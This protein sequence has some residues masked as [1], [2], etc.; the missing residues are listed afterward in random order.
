MK[1]LDLT[2]GA[3]LHHPEEKA[4][5]IELIVSGSLDIISSDTQ[6]NAGPGTIVGLLETPAEDYRFTYL[7][8]ENCVL[9]SYP[10]DKVSDIDR[11]VRDNQSKCDELVSANA[12]VTLALLGHYRRSLRRSDRFCKTITNGYDAYRRLCI[13]NEMEIQPWPLAEG[14]EP[15]T[16]ETD[17]PDWLGDYYDHLGLMPTEV[18]HAF[19]STHSSLTTAAIFKARDHIQLIYGLY[20]Q[21]SSYNSEI[22]ERFLSSSGLYDLYLNLRTRCASRPEYLEQIDQAL[23]KYDKEISKTD[24]LTEDLISRHRSRYINGTAGVEIPPEDTDLPAAGRNA[25]SQ[26]VKPSDKKASVKPEILTDSLELIFDHAGLD[27]DEKENAR[28]KLGE[29]KRLKDKN[30]SDDSV[31][32]LRHEVSRL[33]FSLYEN[34]AIR[35]IESREAA[36]EAVRLFLYFG[37]MDEELTGH[38]NSVKLLRLLNRIDEHACSRLN[39]YTAFDWLKM[40][41]SGERDPSRNEFDQEYST[42]LRSRRQAGEISS[43]EEAA[44]LG[45]PRER[46]HY[47]IENFL[48]MAMRISSGFPSVFCPVLSSHNMIRSPEQTFIDAEKIDDNWNDIKRRDFSLF[49]RKTLYQNDEYKIPQDIIMTEVMPDM[50]LLPMAGARGG[51]WQEISGIRRD[52]RARMY[53]PILSDE[54]LNLIQLR[55]AATF[56]WQICRRTQGVHWNDISTPS[57][58]SEYYD[59]LR[60]F[61]K[62]TDLSSEAR[63]KLRSQIRTC[64]HSYENVFMLD[65]IQWIRFESAGL[66]RLNKVARHLMM[67]YCPLSPEIRKNLATNPMYADMIRRGENLAAKDLKILIARYA[68]RKDAE[69]GLP[70]AIIEYL[71]YYENLASSS[72]SQPQGEN[73][74]S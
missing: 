69:G 63:E 73:P 59:Y 28:K 74:P 18:K 14:L 33:F 56:R 21:L 31:R 7:A 27:D 51:L 34:A 49:F 23:E 6:M 5:T 15:F 10:F 55:L 13:A 29:Y 65:Y 25:L 20:D 53:I 68:K 32:K 12:A 22:R 57:L 38:D 67:L 46:L 71:N 19:Y 37:F 17:L 40:I 8:R 47:E 35:T 58:T 4:E 62:N 60:T 39:V 30:S 16:P 52:S 45:S 70:P 72:F 44:L 66:P 1:K 41:Y 9:E 48:K 50:I 24:I 2:T 42:W 11:L 36:P 64:R 54:D 26:A 3:V 61:R 43:D